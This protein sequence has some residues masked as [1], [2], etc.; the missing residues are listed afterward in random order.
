M[1]RP[2]LIL[3]VFLALAMPAAA[4]FTQVS[5]TVTDPNG[6]PYGGA[7]VSVTLVPAGGNPTL[8]GVPFSAQLT[9]TAD[10]SGTFNLQLADNNI[11]LPGGTQWR[12]S[13]CET[14]GVAPPFGFGSICFTSTQTITGAS[15]SLTVPFTAAAPALTRNIGSGANTALSNLAAVAIN[16]SLL[17]GVAGTVHLGSAT[18]PFGELFLAGTSGTP[19][20][21]NFRITGAS[22]AGTRTVTLADGN[23]VSVIGNAGAANN[24]LSSIDPATGVV[25]N[26]R[27][28]P[29][30]LDPT[31]CIESDGIRIG[32]GAFACAGNRITTDARTT[33]TE[34]I[35]CADVYANPGKLYDFSNAAAIAVSINATIQAGV[36]NC[37]VGVYFYVR[38]SG[39][40]VVTVTPTTVTV[41][42]AATLATAAQYD[43]H[44]WVAQTGGWAAGKM[45][46]TAAGGS[47]V[48]TIITTS[49]QDGTLAAATT[50]YMSYDDS[51]WSALSGVQRGV[52]AAVTARNLCIRTTS[53]QP[54]TGTFVW[55]LVTG[56]VPTATA[57]TVTIAA[58][59]AA[60]TYC[61]NVNTV[62]LGANTSWAIQTVN[63]APAT[64]SAQVRWVAVQFN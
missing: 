43:V 48:G 17:P 30:N 57:L 62:A 6:I 22:T 11:V 16:T 35:T 8:N 14:P 54:G 45:P 42:G 27:P 49:K 60:G 55:T 33:V 40:G 2:I 36:N 34:T 24:F 15:Q 19:G 4:Q 5:A 41:N 44:K 9:A 7:T 32:A 53:A 25:G 58:G 61:D 59:A 26:A 20:T 10:A 39:A 56:D 52:S 47:G 12:F 13:I 3:G 31:G 28:T 21:N 23:S 46:N 38:Q 37:N 63:N 18:L 29:A 50:G 1:K 51:F 64:A